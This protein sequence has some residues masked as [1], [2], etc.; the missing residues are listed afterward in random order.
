MDHYD[1]PKMKAGAESIRTELKKYTAAK[2]AIDATVA[3]LRLRWEDTN[4]D[5]FVLKYNTEAKVAAEN[6][7]ALME[8]F[9]SIL[10]E[11]GTEYEI[12]YSKIR[13]AT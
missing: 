7:A 9:A 12:V 10:E 5:Q 11:S 2:E 6:V 3:D 1:A 13:N 4:H 8:K